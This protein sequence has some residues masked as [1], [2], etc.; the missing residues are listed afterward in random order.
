MSGQMSDVISI[1][2]VEYAIVEPVSDQLFDVR[3]YGVAPVMMHTANTRGVAA[4]YRIDDGQL[5]LADLQV[6]SVDAP[7]AIEGVE[8]TTDEYGQTWTY[9]Q[10]D[11]PI[12]WT[13]DLLVGQGPILE[14]FVHGGFLPVWHYEKVLAFDLEAGV[15]ESSEDRSEQVRA[16]REERTSGGGSGNAAG[17]DTSD[18]A[19]EEDEENVFERFLSSLRIRLGIDE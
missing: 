13:G 7:P 5:L 10:L 2:G 18:G 19:A 17:N 8:A 3:S 11:L 14:L 6:G 12:T 15:V 9:L 1:D 4:R 16:F